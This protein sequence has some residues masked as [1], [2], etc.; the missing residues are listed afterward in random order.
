MGIV[1][2]RKVKRYPI[3]QSPFYCLPTKRRLCGVLKL[4]RGELRGLLAN[5]KYSE[6]VEKKPNGGERLIE[7]PCHP[8]KILQRRIAKLLSRIDLGKELHCPVKGRSYVTNANAHQGAA[9]IRTLD[10]KRYFPS[11][12]SRRVF[13]FWRTVMRCSPDV[14]GILTRLSTHN[15]HLPTGSPLSPVLSFLA[16]IDAWRR[17]TALSSDAGCTLTIYMDDVTISGQNVPSRLLFAI[18]REI[19]RV[20][21]VYHK[22]KCHPSGQGEVTGVIVGGAGLR[23][24]RRQL[25]K[26]HL[27]RKALRKAASDQEM[28]VVQRR[29]RGLIEQA[30]Q[31]CVHA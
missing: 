3:D 30:R 26:L 31:V 1:M 12:S 4:S 9:H 23:L 27:A 13:W 22:E 11:T 14:A 28:Q 2:P 7:D 25:H 24:P 15:E 10:I 17:I 19:R 20:G 16:N 18:R 5:L 6:R 29:I 21:L 8:L